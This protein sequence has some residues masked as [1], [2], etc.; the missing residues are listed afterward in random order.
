MEKEEIPEG[1]KEVRG[2]PVRFRI[3]QDRKTMK[4]ISKDTARSL[5]WIA[6]NNNSIFEAIDDKYVYFGFPTHELQQK[7]LKEAGDLISSLG[8]FGF[9]F[10]AIN[11]ETKLGYEKQ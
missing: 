3:K 11:S 8:A 4:I 2:W 10:E 9:K 7:F 5:D 1:M 6:K